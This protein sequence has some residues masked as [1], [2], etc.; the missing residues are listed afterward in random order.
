MAVYVDLQVASE[1][2]NLPSKET[3]THWA[4]AAIGHA[5]EETE[6]S[7]RI[8]DMEEGAKLNQ[9]WRH[10]PGATNVI[11]FPSDLPEE[12]CLPLIGDLAVCAPVVEREA[13]EQ[14]KSLNAHWAH[15]IIHGTLHLLGYDHIED[16]D[17]LKMEAFETQVL[18]GLGYP[19]PYAMDDIS[20][21]PR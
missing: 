2:V 21:K 13:E 6:I 20:L 11:S 19:A 4:K 15:M 17:A 5:R 3:L 16:S 12:L 1:S 14:N 10:Q 8:V 9:T 7:I 18:T